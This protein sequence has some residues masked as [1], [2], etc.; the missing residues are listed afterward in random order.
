[1]IPILF[2]C[3]KDNDLE[4]GMD[5]NARRVE[6]LQMIDTKGLTSSNF[7]FIDSSTSTSPLRDLVMYNILD[8]P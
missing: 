3:E 5:Y 6:I 2:G 1:M 8:I 7:P 4:N